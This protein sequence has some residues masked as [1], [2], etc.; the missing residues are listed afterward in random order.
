MQK[1]ATSLPHYQTLFAA[2]PVPSGETLY[3]DRTAV[4]LPYA[5]AF[6][7]LH[8]HDRYE[9]GICESGDGLFLSEGNFFSISKGDLVFIA[10]GQR[11]YSRSLKQD[12]PCICRFAYLRAE[13]V[14][15]LLELSGAADGRSAESLKSRSISVPAVIHS[16]EYRRASLILSEIMEV[17]KRDVPN[18]AGLA[19][20]MLSIFIIEAQELFLSSPQTI[21]AAALPQDAAVAM[22]AEYLALHYDSS[23]SAQSLADKC[24]LSESQLRRRFTKAYGI[25]PIAYRNFLRSK[26]AAELLERT[27]L[28]ISEITERI[29][30][31]S[32]SDFYRAFKKAYGTS[33]SAYR[34]KA[35]SD[36]N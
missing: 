36:K 26:V 7:M 31:A 2:L 11:H 14:D 28:P 33:P 19:A 13:T 20:L 34:S 35:T 16:S 4:E 10:P 17:C 30:Y 18:T 27:A 21:P 32:P 23:D 24:Y 15:R 3:F 25:P 6:P 22:T 5:E 1:H 29:G 12:G 8:Y 9:I